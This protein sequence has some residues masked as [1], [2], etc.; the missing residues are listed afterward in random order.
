MKHDIKPEIVL[1]QVGKG[2]DIGTTRLSNDPTIEKT[3]FKRKFKSWSRKASR[4]KL[5][6]PF[7]HLNILAWQGSYIKHCIAECL[8]TNKS[9][10]SLEKGQSDW[11][12]LRNIEERNRN[13]YGAIAR[14]LDE[15]PANIYY[16]ISQSL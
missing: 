4:G 5:S 9:D 15:K 13:E 11:W 3:L 14:R 7:G 16:T 6:S 10:I 8:F 2:N 1:A 12:I